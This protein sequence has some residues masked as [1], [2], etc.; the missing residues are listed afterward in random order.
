MSDDFANDFEDEFDSHDELDD[1][2]NVD[3]EYEYFI[4][5]GLTLKGC[6]GF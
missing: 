1:V 2:E 3:I 6:L 4:L 5:R